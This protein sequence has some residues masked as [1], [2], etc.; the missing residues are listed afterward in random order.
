M[1]IATTAVRA[2]ERSPQLVSACLG[3]LDLA[4]PTTSEEAQ[5][6]LNSEHKVL[7][8]TGLSYSTDGASSYPV[9]SVQVDKMAR[10]IDSPDRSISS[11]EIARI[12]RGA[13]IIVGTCCG[14]F[15]SAFAR[16]DLW[17]P[18]RVCC[19]GNVVKDFERLR[20]VPGFQLDPVSWETVK[21]LVAEKTA[22]SL[23]KLGRAPSGSVVY[24]RFRDEVR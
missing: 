15:A 3:F 4:P 14:L 5:D 6:V 18:L 8:C 16:R 2:L 19:P 11:E 23:G 13:K 17:C 20:P 12:I 24:W 9:T 22:E 21:A 10:G 1:G 7:S